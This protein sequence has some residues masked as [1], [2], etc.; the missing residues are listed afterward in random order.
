MFLLEERQPQTRERGEVRGE[1]R[2]KPPLQRVLGPEE[3]V[4]KVL[5]SWNPEEGYLARLCLK[6]KEEVCVCVILYYK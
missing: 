4:L 2:G 1:A 3:E 6:T 5:N